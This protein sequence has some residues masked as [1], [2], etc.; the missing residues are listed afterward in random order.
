MVRSTFYQ[1]PNIT[2]I[3]ETIINNWTLNITPS[4]LSLPPY[5]ETMA[6]FQPRVQHSN[7]K[8]EAM[9]VCGSMENGGMFC[10]RHGPWTFKKRGCFWQP[11]SMDLWKKGVFFRKGNLH[12]LEKKWHLCYLCMTFMLFLLH[13]Y[14]YILSGTQKRKDEFLRGGFWNQILHVFLQKGGLNW[15]KTPLKGG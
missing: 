2:S 8:M 15:W 4:T 13:T 12:G 10:L 3:P 5:S 11:S 14:L 7:A 6:M 9:L 1:T